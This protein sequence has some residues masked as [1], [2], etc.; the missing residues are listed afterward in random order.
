MSAH[1]LK[2]I[3]HTVLERNDM[4]HYINLMHPS[5]LEGLKVAIVNIIEHN[6]LK[7]NCVSIKITASWVSR[8]VA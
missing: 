3:D 5:K 7:I 1:L 8:L 6:K 4:I 2:S